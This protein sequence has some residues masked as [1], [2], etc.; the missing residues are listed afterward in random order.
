[1]MLGIASESRMEHISRK[2]DELAELVNSRLGHGSNIDRVLSSQA[3]ARFRTM[4]DLPDSSSNL[5]TNNAARDGRKQEGVEC[6]LF[7]H[8]VLATRVL[9]AAV[10]SDPNTEIATEMALALDRLGAVLETQRQRK[11]GPE[12]A[13]PSAR[14]SQSRGNQNPSL[15]PLEKIMPC[16]RMAQGAHLLSLAA[17]L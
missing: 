12:F 2:I 14:L 11:P 5:S 10:A 17:S 16:L 15:P 7:S 13:P 1:M 9:K 4:P 3:H 8:A 6:L